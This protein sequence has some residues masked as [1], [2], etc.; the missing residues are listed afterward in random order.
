LRTAI[1][2][3]EDG[4]AAHC[5]FAQVQEAQEKA[6]LATRE[7]EACVA[8]AAGNKDVES[9]WLSLAQERLPRGEAK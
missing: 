9:I 8:Y 7:W 6:D 4:A 5:L 2:S 3:R 1:A